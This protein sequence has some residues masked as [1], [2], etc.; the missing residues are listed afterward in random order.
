MRKAT[1]LA[2]ALAFLASCASTV[3]PS[4]RVFAPVDLSQ[5]PSVFVSASHLREP[6]ERSLGRAGLPV[7]RTAREASL[8]LI[9]TVGNVRSSTEDCGPVRNV[10]YELRQFGIPLATG[11]AR[12]PVGSC[13]TNVLDQMSRKLADVVLRPPSTTS[14]Q[15]E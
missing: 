1:W 2:C 13:A 9:A 3:P 8:V 6:I 12:G 11:R 14:P 4:F 15:G 5:P 10:K 7:A